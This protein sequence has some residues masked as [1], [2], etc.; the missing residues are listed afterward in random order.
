VKKSHVIPGC[1]LF[2]CLCAVLYAGGTPAA[3]AAPSPTPD[4]AVYLPA[5]SGSQP[6]AA[7]PAGTTPAPPAATGTPVPSATATKTPTATATPAPPRIA[8]IEEFLQKCPTNDPAYPVLRRDFAL[9][10]DGEVVNG[11]FPCTEPFSTQ[12]IEQLTNELVVL[13]VLRTAYYMHSETVGRLPWTGKGLYDWM[14]TSVAGVNMV[15]TPGKLYC[16]DWFDHRPYFVFSLQDADQ[17]DHKRTWKGISNSLAFY[18]H[19]I[20]HAAGGPGH[21]AGCA[22]FPV[23]AGCDATYDLA[24]LGSF[25]VQYWLESSWVSGAISVGIA[26]SD[27]ATAQ[28]YAEWLAQAANGHRERIVANP[29]PEVTASEPYGGPCSR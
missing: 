17:R 25:G 5:I 6:T 21:V 24:N 15:S 26:C 19:E 27:P 13:Q 11:P 16:C 3:G 28:D 14:V 23:V 1:V 29:P 4:A 12:P 9:R 18:S 22:G 10:I 20:R 7:P 8:A 2:L